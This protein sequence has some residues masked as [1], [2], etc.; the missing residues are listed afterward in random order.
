MLRNGPSGEPDLISL[1]SLRAALFGEIRKVSL[2]PHK[3]NR[4]GTADGVLLGGNLSV[5]Q[6][7][8]GTCC[9]PE[10]NGKILFIEDVGEYLYH[11]D[12]MVMNQKLRGRLAHL[13]ALIVGDMSG[14][15]PSPSGFTKPAYRILRDAVA[16]YDYP[17]MFGFPSGHGTPNLSLFLGREVAL[18]VSA[19]KC[20]LTY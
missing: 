10:V 9:E 6:S 3:L 20:T 7:I 14:M 17:V 1:D 15:K 2:S 16:E 4:T 12:R 19:H 18:E 5:L 13:K 11:I 8:A